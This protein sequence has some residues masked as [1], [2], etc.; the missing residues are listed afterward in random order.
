MQEHPVSFKLG[1]QLY[2]PVIGKLLSE[3][4]KDDLSFFLIGD[5]P[6]FE[7]YISLHL[8]AFLEELHGMFYLEVEVVLVGVGSETDL[9]HHRFRGLGLRLFFFLLLL[10]EELLVIYDPANGWV[11]RWYDLHKIQL[12]F[13]GKPPG[14]F[15]GVNI[16][17]DVFSDEPDT[18]CRYIFIDVV[19][20]LFFLKPGAWSVAAWSAGP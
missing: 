19:L 13:F 15:K 4:Q 9:L 7:V 18:W 5:G 3:F 11:C 6:A 20:V 2:F 8:V 10:I 17:C 1:Q 14:V 12:P 16:G